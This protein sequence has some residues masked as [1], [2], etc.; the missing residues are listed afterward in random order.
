MNKVIAV[1][2]TQESADQAAAELA[3]A[4]YNTDDIKVFNRDDLSNGHIHVKTS[5]RFDRVEIGIC[6]AIGA[7]LGVLTGLGFITIPGFWYLSSLGVVR[8]ALSG[9]IFGLV[10]GIVVAFLTSLIIY[11]TTV[12]RNEKYLNEGKYLLFYD[13]H[14]RRDI[15]RAHQILHTEDVPVELSAH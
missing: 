2:E 15:K 13:G 5:H 1:Y 14:T 6:V 4:G 11:F 3:N 9:M 10:L 12:R 7:L 8:G